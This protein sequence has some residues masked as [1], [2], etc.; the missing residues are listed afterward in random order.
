MGGVKGAFD[1]TVRWRVGDRRLSFALDTAGSLSD[2]PVDVEGGAAEGGAVAP[3][4]GAVFRGI[5]WVN[6]EL[7][8]ADW[9]SDD[10]PLQ[11]SFVPTVGEPLFLP[12]DGYHYQVRL[13]RR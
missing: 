3:G 6:L 4:Q 5:A 2:V 9:A 8:L 1:G 13:V 7:P 11:L 10:T 12:A